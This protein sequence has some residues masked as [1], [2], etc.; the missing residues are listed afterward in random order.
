MTFEGSSTELLVE[1]SWFLSCWKKVSRVNWAINYT[2]S[3]HLQIEA[4]TAFSVMSHC[5]LD[6]SL[7][8]LKI[9]RVNARGTV[10][11]PDKFRRHSLTNNREICIHLTWK[12]LHGHFLF[13]VLV[14]LTF[15]HRTRKCIQ[16]FYKSSSTNIPD[17][18]EI[19]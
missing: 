14:S 6:L 15:D 17:L 7:T 18:R 11:I 19:K 2:I 8:N 4:L 13:C 12:L 5:D 9:Q 1:M 3:R 10:Y 16:L